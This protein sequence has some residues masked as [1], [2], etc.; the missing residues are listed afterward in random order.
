M[1]VALKWIT[2]A[3]HEPRRCTSQLFCLLQGC[4]SLS[5]L[6]TWSYKA[7]TLSQSLFS[8]NSSLVDMLH[9]NLFHK[10]WFVFLLSSKKKKICHMCHISCKKSFPPSSNFHLQ[11]SPCYQIPL[12]KYSGQLIASSSS[13][14]MEY[15]PPCFMLLFSQ[16]LQKTLNGSI[17]K[18]IILH[19][20]VSWNNLSD[21]YSLAALP[22][23][24]KI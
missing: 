17:W 8:G 15:Y 1:A 5:R 24:S 7:K 2:R 11:F 23:S 9:F 20:L 12:N 19:S 10:L 4:A 14:L 22:L 18:T 16:Y 21:L 6:S 3:H 13:M